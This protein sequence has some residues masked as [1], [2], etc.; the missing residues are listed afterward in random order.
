MQKGSKLSILV[1]DP[2]PNWLAEWWQCARF[3]GTNLTDAAE[4]T[5]RLLA[6]WDAPIGN[7]W[8]RASDAQLLRQRYRRGDSES[9]HPGEHT[10]EAAILADP[11]DELRCFAG[12]VVDGLNAVPLARDP[13]GKRKH[14]VEADIFLLVE[15]ANAHQVLVVEVKDRSNNAWYAIV[16]NLLQLRLARETDGSQRLFAARANRL[17]LGHEV[18]QQPLPLVGVVLAPRSFY[19]A[20]GRKSACLGAARDLLSAFSSKGVLVRLAVWESANRSIELLESPN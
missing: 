16:E 18:A 19:E 7:S 10:I 11:L 9:P 13:G 3:T 6:L 1:S 17:S 5:K 12:R 2:Y 20:R 4:R 14:N 15:R 8:H